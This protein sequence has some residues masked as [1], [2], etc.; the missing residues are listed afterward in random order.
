M[1]MMKKA[2]S[3]LFVLMTLMS[4]M[5]CRPLAGLIIDEKLDRSVITI[6]R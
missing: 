6:S 5:G 3:Y 4:F 1:K 2:L